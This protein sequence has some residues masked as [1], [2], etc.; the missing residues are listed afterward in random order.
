MERVA[1][2]AGVGE[3]VARAPVAAGLGQREELDLAADGVERGA[4][5]ADRSLSADPRGRRVRRRRRG[6]TEGLAQVDEVARERGG[7]ARRVGA[8]FGER[9]ERLGGPASERR[10]ARRGERGELDG[11]ARGAG[12]DR[13]ARLLV[14]WRAELLDRVLERV[15]FD[16]GLLPGPGAASGPR[17]LRVRAFVDERP[18]ALTPGSALV[19]RCAEPGEEPVQPRHGDDSAGVACRDRLLDGVDRLERRLH[20]G[21]REPDRPDRARRA[22]PRSRARSARRLRDRGSPPIP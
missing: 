8:S 18:A 17:A 12:R 22:S 16:E 11:D 5:H 19:R 15:H 10:R 2:R 1:H 21:A 3:H 9:R 20:R 6:A 4:E 14:E 7:G 13:A